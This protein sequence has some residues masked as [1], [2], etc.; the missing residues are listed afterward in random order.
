MANVGLAISPAD[1][2]PY[3]KIYA[4]YVSPYDGG[5]GVF[6]EV[7]DILLHSRGQLLPLIQTLSKKES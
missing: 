6:R 1:A 3:V 7:G 4:H 2:L 5:K